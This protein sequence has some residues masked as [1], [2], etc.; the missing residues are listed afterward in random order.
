MLVSSFSVVYVRVYKKY[1]QNRNAAAYCPA[2]YKYSRHVCGSGASS[3]RGSGRV[4][5][6][7]LSKNAY[8]NSGVGGHCHCCCNCRDITVECK[9]K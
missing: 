1:P 7:P 3:W 2:G 5:Y 9:R 8:L 4:D 6:G